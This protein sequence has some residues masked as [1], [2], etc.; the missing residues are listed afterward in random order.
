MSSNYVHGRVRLA[1]G[2]PR[3]GEY[4]YGTRTYEPADYYGN[5]FLY[6]DDKNLLHQ[7]MNLYT[8]SSPYSGRAVATY[9]P[10]T[11]Y[12]SPS[13]SPI[14]VF[15]SAYMAGGQSGSDLDML[16]DLESGEV[17]AIEEE[18]FFEGAINGIKNWWN[19]LSQSD[20]DYLKNKGGELIEGQTSSGGRSGTGGRKASQRLAKRLDKMTLEELRNGYEMVKLIPVPN[21]RRP[22]LKKIRQEII[23]R[24]FINSQGGVSSPKGTGTFSPKAGGSG[25]SSGS[26][27]SGGAGK[28]AGGG[29]LL[30]GAGA[31]ALLAKLLL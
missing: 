20:K 15:G 5:H 27:G 30:L 28:K 17:G 16:N 1:T 3:V 10:Q 13:T 26:G 29:G 2:S 6:A 14:G 12:N 9:P 8:A 7:G 23:G 4:E 24:L 11:I 21:I 25:G 19:S 22:I 18:G 31:L